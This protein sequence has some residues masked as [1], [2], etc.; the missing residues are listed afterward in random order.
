M[1]KTTRAELTLVIGA[2]GHLGNS[3]VRASVRN[4]GNCQPCEGMEVSVE[5]SRDGHATTTI[6]GPFIDQAAQCG[7]LSRV[8]DLG[9]PLLL[10]KPEA[11]KHVEDSG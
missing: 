11:P 3:L 10:V 8:G 2:N 6:A 4:P 5:L 7:L 9:L 1:E